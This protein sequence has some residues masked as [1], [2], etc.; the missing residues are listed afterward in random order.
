LYVTEEQDSS[1]EVELSDMSELSVNKSQ[2][3]TVHSLL[4]LTVMIT[5]EYLVHLQESIVV[6]RTNT[7]TEKY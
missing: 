5:C 2:T 7:D 6:W 4:Q 1:E 3:F